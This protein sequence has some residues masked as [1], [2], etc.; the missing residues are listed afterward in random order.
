MSDDKYSLILGDR[1]WWPEVTL[2]G[3]EK[4]WP[5]EFI[6]TVKQMIS[7]CRKNAVGPVASRELISLAKTNLAGGIKVG[8]QSF[9]V[10]VCV[11]NGH[12]GS[13]KLTN[14]I[15]I[16]RYPSGAIKRIDEWQTLT[17]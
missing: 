14:F 7:C 17:D 5:D 9:E 11:S 3:N 1:T 6:S 8:E 4:K 2:V 13:A 15:L 12:E 16:P 10:A